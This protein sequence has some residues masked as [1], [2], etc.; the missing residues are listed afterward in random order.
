MTHQ[1][2]ACERSFFLLR[3]SLLAYSER[4]IFWQLHGTENSGL[5]DGNDTLP[6]ND[7]D[8]VYR[9]R[10]SMGAN[11]SL[12]RNSDYE[13]SISDPGCRQQCSSMI[14]RWLLS[15]KCDFGSFL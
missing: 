1:V 5:N 13:L 15:G 12:R 6:P 4:L 11:E 2:W 8:S 7:G 10:S 3:G 9:I 14:M